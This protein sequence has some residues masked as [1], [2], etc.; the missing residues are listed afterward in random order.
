MQEILSI[1][2]EVDL[3]G[4]GTLGVLTKPDLVNRGDEWYIMDLVHKTKN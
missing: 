3:L 2:E 1:A 4:Q